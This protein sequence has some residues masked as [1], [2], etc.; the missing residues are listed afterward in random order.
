[1]NK[2]NSI[3]KD[4][5]VALGSVFGFYL[6][7]K[8]A[9]V[10]DAWFN[11]PEVFTLVDVASTGLQIATASA[12]AWILKRL[13]FSHTLGKDFGKVFDEGWSQFSVKEKTQWIIISFL[14]LFIGCVIASMS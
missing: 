3:K 10:L 13:I 14:S 1:M 11:L 12:F 7:L 5:L 6:I 4:V 9:T 2:D 8:L